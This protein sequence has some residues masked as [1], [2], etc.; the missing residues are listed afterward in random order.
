MKCISQVKI[1]L[2]S[3]Q[4]C[5]LL[6]ADC[7]WLQFFPLRMFESLCVTKYISVP[8]WSATSSADPCD[9]RWPGGPVLVFAVCTL[10][11]PVHCVKLETNGRG[12]LFKYKLQT[13]NVSSHGHR[14]AGPRETWYTT[15]AATAWLNSRQSAPGIEF[16][17]I[18]PSRTWFD[19]IVSST[20]LV[21]SE[22]RTHWRT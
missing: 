11:L 20:S 9:L 14:W 5:G 10:I 21:K 6:V 13:L 7:N 22:I 1:E 8:S 4:L 18:G 12:C 16:K 19:S 2:L 3:K 15:P 17:C